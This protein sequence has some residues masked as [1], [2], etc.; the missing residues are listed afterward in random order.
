MR[1]KDKLSEMHC[2]LFIKMIPYMLYEYWQFSKHIARCGMSKDSNKLLTDILMTTHAIEK[3]FS[4]DNKRK[5]FGLKKVI[6]LTNNI[7]KYIRKYGYSERLNV[8]VALVNSYLVFQKNDGF[9]G[10][11]LD[12]VTN[13]LKSIIEL[14]HISD[15]VFHEAGFL[16]KTKAQMIES[17]SVDFG[18]LANNRYSFRHFSKE[19]VSDELIRKALDIAKKSPSA[20]N[21]QSYRAHIF[22]GNDKDK[23]LKLQGGANSFYNEANKAILIT[24]DMNRYYTTEMHLPYVD[25][26]LFAMSLIYALTSIGVASIPLTMG[27]KLNVLK[28]MHYMMNIPMNEV[29]VILIAIGHYPDK[30]EISMSHR[31]DVE[32]F[33]TF[34]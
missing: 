31:N 5:G 6:S 33:T 22:S 27:R 30:A 25:G 11:S 21:R 18:M 7:Q 24:S 14:C 16:V 23:I 2:L 3:A 20:C 34:H 17:T 19:D 1:L 4:L 32:S 15:E 26:S 10:K 28:K 13:K 12:E 9:T 8:S 29:P